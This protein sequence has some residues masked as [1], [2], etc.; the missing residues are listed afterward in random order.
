MSRFYGD[1]AGGAQ[2]QTVI[3]RRSS[4]LQKLCGVFSPTGV[5][6][7]LVEE[8]MAA[9]PVLS[10]ALTGSLPAEATAGGGVGSNQ[11]SKNARGG[12]LE[13]LLLDKIIHS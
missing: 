10:A 6:C 3:T 2:R 5:L 4:G 1:T 11:E 12:N 9:T 7:G 13:E 8:I